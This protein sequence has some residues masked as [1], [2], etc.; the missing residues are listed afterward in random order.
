MYYPA[1]APAVADPSYKWIL[2]DWVAYDDIKVYQ[3][4]SPLSHHYVPHYQVVVDGKTTQYFFG[5]F[6]D[7]YA[8]VEERYQ[9]LL[10]LR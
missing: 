1:T 2:I 7:V 8:Y 5:D 3:Q 9:V 6:K 4:Y 10:G